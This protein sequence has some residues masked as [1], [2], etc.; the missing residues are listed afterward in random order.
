MAETQE[1][2]TRIE[3]TGLIPANDTDTAIMVRDAIERRDRMIAE[4]LDNPLFD[5]RFGDT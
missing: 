5:Y 4:H 3:I 2:G 1:W